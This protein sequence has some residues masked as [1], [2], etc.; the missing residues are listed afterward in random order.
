MLSAGGN[1]PNG[2]SDARLTQDLL[3][4]RLFSGKNQVSLQSPE[5][6]LI[7]TLRTLEIRFRHV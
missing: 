7:W 2:P 5:Q 1:E 3:K 4:E 6:T